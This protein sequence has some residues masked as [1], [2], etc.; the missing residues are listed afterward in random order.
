MISTNRGLA[1]GK[2]SPRLFADVRLL[3][4]V[5]QGLKSTVLSMSVPL[6]PGGGVYRGRAEG[7]GRVFA[8]SSALSL[9]TAEGGQM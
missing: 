3:I 9:R 5:L 7:S 6:C 8:V 1:A 2:R 4:H